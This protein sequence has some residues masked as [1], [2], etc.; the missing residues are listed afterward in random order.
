MLIAG[1]VSLNG[2]YKK[3]RL[4]QGPPFI[5]HNYP[6]RISS[7]ILM[8]I[9]LLNQGN[10]SKPNFPVE[11]VRRG[12]TGGASIATMHTTHTT[13]FQLKTFRDFFSYQ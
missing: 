5:L 4:S 9:Y 12:N 7:S 1:S 2:I 10:I 8:I 3:L 6:S 13:L 11:L